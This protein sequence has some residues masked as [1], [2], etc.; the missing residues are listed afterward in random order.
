[1]YK[2]M[3][4]NLLWPLF[5]FSYDYLWIL[6]HLSLSNYTHLINTQHVQIHGIDVYISG[7]AGTGIHISYCEHIHWNT[8]YIIDFYIDNFKA[9][10]NFSPFDF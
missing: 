10:K 6:H 4:A 5:P 8:K 1:M 2:Y 3:V 7:T 9:S